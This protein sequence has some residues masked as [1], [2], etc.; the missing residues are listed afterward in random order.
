L[1]LTVLAVSQDGG[2][3]TAQATQLPVTFPCDNF[4]KSK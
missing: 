3:H 2:Y 1:N 4:V